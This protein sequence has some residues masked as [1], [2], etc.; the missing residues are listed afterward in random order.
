MVVVARRRF[1]KYAGHWGVHREACCGDYTDD[2]GEE[3]VAV[4]RCI[5][6]IQ[7]KRPDIVVSVSTQDDIFS[8]LGPGGPIWVGLVGSITLPKAK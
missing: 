8:D 6:C 5:I 3:L 1:L 7:R 4:C 2:V